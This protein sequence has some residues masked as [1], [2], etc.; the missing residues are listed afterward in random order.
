[1]SKP[2]TFHPYQRNSVRTAGPA[3]HHPSDAVPGSVSKTASS[4]ANAANENR[5]SGSMFGLLSTS[6]NPEGSHSI[7]PMRHD[8]SGLRSLSALRAASIRRD[9]DIYGE[10]NSFLRNSL[11]SSARSISST[12][13]SGT[14][15][16]IDLLADPE[17]A[18]L[19]REVKELREERRKLTADK[20]LLERRVLDLEERDREKES[21]VQE[22]LARSDQLEADRRLLFE[23]HKDMTKQVLESEQK[24]LLVDKKSAT[25]VNALSRENDELRDELSRITREAKSSARTMRSEAE[26]WSS[27]RERFHERLLESQNEVTKQVDALKAARVELGRYEAKLAE[28]EATIRK[29]KTGTTT[30]EDID[31]LQRQLGDQVKHIRNLET[32]NHQLMEKNTYLRRMQENTEKL[33]DEKLSLERQLARMADIQRTCTQLEVEISQL[34]SEKARWTTFLEASGEKALDSPYQFAKALADARF[35]LALLKEKLGEESAKRGGRETYIV[36][37]ESLVD[38]LR[39]KFTEMEN[40]RHI[41][42]RS[43]KRVE[44][45]RQLAL[46]EV[47]I[48]REQLRSYD[49]EE[50]NLMDGNYDQ[51]KTMRIESL[52][53]MVD[54]YKTTV[55]HLEEE[56]N[57]LQKSIPQQTV[58][59]VVRTISLYSPE[60]TQKIESLENIIQ[61]QKQENAMLQKE[62]T[63]LEEQLHGLQRALGRGEYDIGKVR[64]LELR[65]NPERKELA[66]RQAMLDALA[67]EN[68]Q[69]T[70]Q[71]GTLARAASHGPSQSETTMALGDSQTV[72]SS[73]LEPLRLQLSHLQQ[74]LNEKD[75]RMQ[76][77]KTTFQ[78][79]VQE[80]REAVFS[81][82]GYKL[83]IDPN[84]R[85]KLTCMYNKTDT[86]VL[87]VTGLN[88][89]ECKFE[90]SGGGASE[91]E[92]IRE[93]VGIFVQ[94]RG[95]VPG[96][97]AGNML[98]LMGMIGGA[99]GNGNLSRDLPQ[100]IA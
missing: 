15:G 97:L 96:F 98:S 72:S 78:A 70:E 16:S 10:F 38:D 55:H 77:L 45:T 32:Q 69:L 12:G 66:I 73:T 3:S 74:S 95:S 83:E 65:D 62:A 20:A 11:R 85:I 57:T 8:G 64:V 42:A 29:L 35:E 94:G 79:K 28:A 37:L 1:M 39:R 82:L 5:A 50:A 86:P 53:R 18:K 40:G 60:V 71:I 19:R 51:Q 58:A 36:E 92:R 26:A 61:K 93:L 99:A 49:V 14:T 80:Y 25:K 91:F 22:L 75:T 76:R 24:A 13:T 7:G 2:P 87:L 90:L 48:L 27:E 81:L 44:R 56:L 43:L 59:E 54:D 67:C 41:D 84:S 63:S 88:E 23:R 6:A 31:I 52:E 9:D 4:A 46:K 100:N 21:K 47:E 17:L 33:K 30:S 68:K 89:G 34:K